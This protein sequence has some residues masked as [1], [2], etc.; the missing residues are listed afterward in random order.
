MVTSSSFYRPISWCEY[1]KQ[2]EE[3]QQ[4][5]KKGKLKRYPES[6]V[7][8]QKKHLTTEHI[9]KESAKSPSRKNKP[10]KR[11]SKGLGKNRNSANF[12]FG[13]DVDMKLQVVEVENEVVEVVEDATAENGASPEGDSDDVTT[14][15]QLFDPKLS[16]EEQDTDKAFAFLDEYDIAS[17]VIE[18]KPAHQHA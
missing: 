5:K 12:S 16:R 13:S 6:E 7:N 10:K 18:H 15:N 9:L 8:N 2:E 14:T 3:K 11:E 4:A 1:W 17:D